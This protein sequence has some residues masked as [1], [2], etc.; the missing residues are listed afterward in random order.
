MAAPPSSMGPS[1]S[2]YQDPRSVHGHYGQPPASSYPP[3]PPSS[4]AQGPY[5]HPGYPSPQNAQNAQNVYDEASR[6]PSSTS[7]TAP[8]RVFVPVNVA[9]QS[10]LTPSPAGM[11]HGPQQG[12]MGPGAPGQNMQL[13]PAP[14][15]GRLPI[16]LWFLAFAIVGFG[17]VATLHYVFDV[18]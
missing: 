8:T 7:Q 18:F 9:G 14:Q 2:P 6:G 13:Q 4:H 11:M 15:P 10:G 17:I 12:S 1:P 3:S 16:V 5:N